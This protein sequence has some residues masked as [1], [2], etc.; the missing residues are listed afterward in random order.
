MMRPNPAT[1]A[2]NRPS[3]PGSR[4]R[5]LVRGR[6]LPARTCRGALCTC[7]CTAY[8]RYLLPRRRPGGETASSVGTVRWVRG[9]LYEMDHQGTINAPEAVR[10]VGLAADG[11][12]GAWECLVEHFQEFVAA[13]SEGGLANDDEARQDPPGHGPINHVRLCA[14]ER[15]QTASDALLSLPPRWQQ[16]IHLLMAGPPAPRPVEE[17][18]KRA[19]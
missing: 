1:R 10:L 16:L 2:G 8:I 15:T 11:D 14:T 5:Q 19:G 4:R 12:I 18:R 17:S 6:E 7:T 13:L 9:G 3:C